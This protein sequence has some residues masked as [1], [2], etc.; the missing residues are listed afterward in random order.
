M[1]EGGFGNLIALPL[2]GEA[3]KNG[4][5]VFVDG[6]D[7]PYADQWSFLSGLRHMDK[8]ELNKHISKLS[9]DGELGSLR[10]ESEGK[11]GK[12]WEKK[13]QSK[14]TVKDFPSMVKIVEA[15]ML[16]IDKG[17]IS[18]RAINRLKRLAAFSNPV[19]YRTQAVRESVWD[20][21]IPRIISCSVDV[22]NYLCLP[23]GCKN[24]I[25]AT[26]DKT[27][28]EW[29]DERNKGRTIDVEFNGILRLEQGM[30][31]AEMQSYENG[32][33]AVSTAYGKTV[34]G[35]AL[36]AQRRVNT[37]ILVDTLSLLEQWELRLKEFL[38]I[39]ESL[40]ELPAKKGRKKQSSIIGR[41]GGGK[42]NL[43]GIIDIATYQSLVRGEVVKDA[44]KDYGMVIIDECHHVAAPSFER[45]LREVNATY[46]YGLTATPKRQDGHHPIITMQCG[47]I[48]YKDDPKEQAQNRPFEHFYIPR[49][50]SYRLPI[51]KNGM[52]LQDIYTDL[53]QCER[54]NGMI[55][56]DILQA[57]DE[58]R[59]PLV[60]SNR[61]VQI[62]LLE[63]VLKEKIPN[64]IVL[65][66]GKTQNERSQQTEQVASVSEDQPLVIIATGSYVGEGFDAPRLDTLFLATPFSWEGTLAQY[67][68][69]LHRLHDG[70]DEVLI[71]DYVDVYI[72]RLE[73]MY[74]KRMKGYSSIGYLP[75]CEGV[76]P[77]EGNIIYDGL[78]FLPVFSS[79]LLSAKREIVIVS[80][81]LTHKRVA[82]M[83][84]ILEECAL[85]GVEVKVITRPFG[86]YAEKDSNTVSGLFAHLSD[87]G[88]NVVS[89]SKIHQKFAV[90]DDWIVWYGSINLLS[91]G[92]SE[93]SIMRLESATIAG[94]L[95]S[96]LRGEETIWKI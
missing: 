78:S 16:F 76:I 17:G 34:I 86:D 5:S 62:D 23:R 85:S 28:I 91:Y 30:A 68:G 79:D 88:V 77:L 60:L 53:S 82:K 10:V 38:I 71:Y 13:R 49:F 74:A 40:P 46:I 64:L 70:K 52:G 90:I 87:K 9:R 89:K 96:V 81:Y 42:K 56:A 11:D 65:T 67:T 93:E 95:M 1:P 47:D 31:L 66:G 21:K 69:R 35:I 39:N 61:L 24:D 12:P 22:D 29:Q 55:I 25:I 72:P 45:V 44:V 20:R 75:K 41:L 54:R 48:R 33:L 36:I 37:L 80:P 50:T 63:N 94:E 15:N 27:P 19:F 59:N 83:V 4:N 2:Q 84:D 92:D 8:D 7:K 43:S 57:V 6:F 26:L 32:V 58:G 14:L 18:A 51:D 3:R 73:N